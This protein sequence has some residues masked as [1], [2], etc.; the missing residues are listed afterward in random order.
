V[1]NYI[2]ASKPFKWRI[3]RSVKISDNIFMDWDGITSDSPELGSLRRLFVYT[4]SIVVEVNVG[5]NFSVAATFDL[6]K[7][8]GSFLPRPMTRI[9][10][11]SFLDDF[12][13]ISRA[14][15]DFSKPG[16]VRMRYRY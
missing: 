2:D 16:E 9:T 11:F 15:D 14:P 13:Y 4:S 6:N 5:L 8:S 10:S 3:D 1:Y 12:M 7:L